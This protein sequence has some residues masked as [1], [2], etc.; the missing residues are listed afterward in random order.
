MLEY[1]VLDRIIIGDKTVVIVYGNPDR[2]SVGKVVK[3]TKGETY[4]IESV[5]SPCEN[6]EGIMTNLL[7]Q[8][9]FKDV[10]FVF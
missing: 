2:F 10:S 4:K 8:G 6:I 5:V 7:L 9:K 1:K 3:D